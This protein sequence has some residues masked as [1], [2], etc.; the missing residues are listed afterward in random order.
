M[1]RKKGRNNN[2][3]KRKLNKKLKHKNNF[4][5]RYV[6]PCNPVKVH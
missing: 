4:I 3:V 6:I 2:E 5:C 1:G